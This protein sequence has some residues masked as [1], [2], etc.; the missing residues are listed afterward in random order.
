MWCLLLKDIYAGISQIQ[1][2]KLQA[3]FNWCFCDVFVII[4]RETA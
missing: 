4:W 2:D 3:N 1:N